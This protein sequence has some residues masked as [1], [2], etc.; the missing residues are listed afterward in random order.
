MT[1]RTFLAASASGLALRAAASER[2]PIH[3]AVLFSML[4]SQLS[5]LDR[6]QL[7]RDT[8]FEPT[9]VKPRRSSPRARKPASGF[10]P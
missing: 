5:I 7:A 1:R 6:F 2:L 3:K 4:P 9:S 8:G 10:T